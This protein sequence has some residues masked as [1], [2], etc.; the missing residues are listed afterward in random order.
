MQKF[1]CPQC[2]SDQI[3]ADRHFGRRL[4]GREFLRRV[5]RSPFFWIGAALMIIFGWVLGPINAN[6]PDWRFWLYVLGYV[7]VFIPA[8]RIYLQVYRRGQ[9]REDNQILLTCRQCGHEWC[10]DDSVITQ[11][12]QKIT[13]V[14]DLPLAQ[15]PL[16]TTGA[17]LLAFC[18][19]LVL[20]TLNYVRLSGEIC[21]GYQTDFW[22]YTATQLPVAVIA[23]GV[24]AVLARRTGRRKAII[25]GVVIFALLGLVS[26]CLMI[27][28]AGC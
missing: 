10:V 19:T 13:T 6:N 24:S 26:C 18:I 25:L 9:A 7:L 2:D 4:K 15:T 16:Q 28:P 27:G 22:P 23:A 17:A 21:K 8:V 11:M 20:S 1:R 5:V 14:D 3:T 12:A